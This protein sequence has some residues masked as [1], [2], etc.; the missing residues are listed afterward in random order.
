MAKVRRKASRLSPDFAQSPGG[1]G[2]RIMQ[3]PSVHKP[4]RKL[5][6]GGWIAI[7]AMGVILGL[8]IWYAFWGYNLTDATIDEVGM[9]SL[10]LGVV[11]SMVLGGGLMALMFWSNRKGYD[12]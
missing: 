4:K 2:T 11:M 9:V 12:R 8:S 7:V 5:G 6:T 10:I 1:L 3:E